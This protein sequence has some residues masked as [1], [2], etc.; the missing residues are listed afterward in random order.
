[1]E[2]ER[3]SRSLK[4]A[5]ESIQ[6]EE[7][8][9]IDEVTRNAVL[10]EIFYSAAYDAAMD[11]YRDEKRVPPGFHDVMSH[12]K[13]EMVSESEDSLYRPKKKGKSEKS[14]STLLGLLHKK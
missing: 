6:S 4:K 13:E 5:S 10:E 2:P 9:G 14:H 3:S 7:Y 12:Q 1:M 8:E 11:F